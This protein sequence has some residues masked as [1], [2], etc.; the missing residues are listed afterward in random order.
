MNAYRTLDLNACTQSTT[1]AQPAQAFGQ[2]VMETLLGAKDREHHPL[3]G[4]TMLHLDV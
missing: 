2:C 3:G 4:G 1:V